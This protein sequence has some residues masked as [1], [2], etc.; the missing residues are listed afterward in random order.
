MDRNDKIQQ[1]MDM[2]K[3]KAAD[4]RADQ[5]SNAGGAGHAYRL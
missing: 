3:R 5:G 2:V 1:I 4:G